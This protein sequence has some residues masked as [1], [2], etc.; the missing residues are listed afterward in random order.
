VTP[1]RIQVTVPINTD[2]LYE[3]HPQ[4]YLERELRRYFTTAAVAFDDDESIVAVVTFAAKD[5]HTLICRPGSDDDWLTF[6]NME[7]GT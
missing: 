2:D 7:D 5:F 6:S 1:V 4:L 3:S